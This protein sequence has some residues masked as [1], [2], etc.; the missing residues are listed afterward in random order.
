[1]YRMYWCDTV[2]LWYRSLRTPFS[3]FLN[4]VRKDREK[5]CAQ[6][7]EKYIIDE[8]YVKTDGVRKDG[9]SRVGMRSDCASNALYLYIQDRIIYGNYNK[10]LVKASSKFLVL[11]TN[12]GEQKIYHR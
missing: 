12:L 6:R 8:V 10:K 1:M 5:R 11:L 3:D 9:V 4:G 2:F 7:L